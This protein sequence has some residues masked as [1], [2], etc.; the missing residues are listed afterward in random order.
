MHNKHQGDVPK[1]LVRGNGDFGQVCPIN[2]VF[3]SCFSI[4]MLCRLVALNS[5]H[6]LSAAEPFSGNY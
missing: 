1:N 6:A 5:R 3:R 4:A 2:S